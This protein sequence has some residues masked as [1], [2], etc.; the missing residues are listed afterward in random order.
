MVVSVRRS[1]P[2]GR[3]RT[4]YARWSSSRYNIRGYSRTAA[5]RGRP[6]ASFC[7]DRQ[8][9]ASCLLRLKSAAN[10][11]CL[12]ASWPPH[13]RCSALAK[14]LCSLQWRMV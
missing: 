5:W 14:G 4:R 8:V 10:N 9:S 2:W 7:L 3:P 12:P 6:R 13:V 1:V 11:T